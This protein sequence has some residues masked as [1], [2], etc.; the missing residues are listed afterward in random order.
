MLEVISQFGSAVVLATLVIR[1]MATSGRH[2]PREWHDILSDFRDGHSELSRFANLNEKKGTRPWAS[3]AWLAIKGTRGLWRIYK[4][5]H[6]L[7]EV[8]D[9]LGTRC[10]SD[11]RVSERLIAAR[12]KLRTTQVMTA[13]ILV[14][15]VV[16]PPLRGSI[17]TSV[18]S[19]YVATIK[20]ISG[21]IDE[22]FPNLVRRYR[23]FITRY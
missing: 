21:V 2:S 14:G 18:L 8:V 16:A 23:Y 1:V 22:F 15:A 6:V 13:V 10:A 19:S 11:P 3:E 20:I 4:N 12:A 5:V 17:V 7:L 9:F